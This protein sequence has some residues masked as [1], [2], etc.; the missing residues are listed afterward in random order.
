MQEEI[1][2]AFESGGGWSDILAEFKK[3]AVQD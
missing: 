3:T 1:R 2:K